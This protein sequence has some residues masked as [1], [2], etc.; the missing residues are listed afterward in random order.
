MLKFEIKYNSL[1]GDNQ[2]GIIVLASDEDKKFEG[3]CGFI[4]ED[5]EDLL[6]IFKSIELSVNRLIEHH[7]GRPF[8][9]DRIHESMSQ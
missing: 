7:N 9:E 5:I 4:I 6:Y 1:I 2:K 3:S 8:L